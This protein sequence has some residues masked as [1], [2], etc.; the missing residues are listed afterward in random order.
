MK[1]FFRVT[2]PFENDFTNHNSVSLAQV[3]N[4]SN[5]F[6]EKGGIGKVNILDFSLCLGSL[7]QAPGTKDQEL[8]LVITYRLLLVM[9]TMIQGPWIFHQSPWRPVPAL[10][11]WLKVH[12]SWSLQKVSR[13]SNLAP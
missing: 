5:F 2:I 6:C 8:L 11:P 12:G 9:I 13:I 1:N 3:H 4:I 7:G 10:N